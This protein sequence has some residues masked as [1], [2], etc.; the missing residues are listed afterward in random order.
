MVLGLKDK[1]SAVGLGTMSW[2]KYRSPMTPSVTEIT[3]SHIAKKWWKRPQ[4][5]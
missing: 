1:V 2:M 4:E 3:D 5:D